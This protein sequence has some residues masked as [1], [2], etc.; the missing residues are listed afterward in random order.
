MK[1]TNTVAEGDWQLGREVCFSWGERE[2]V[3]LIK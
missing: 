2:P 3:H 1:Q